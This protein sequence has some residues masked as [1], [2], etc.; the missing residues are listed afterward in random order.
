MA[1]RAGAGD[2]VVGL[3]DFP[4]A[5]GTAW[6]RRVIAVGRAKARGAGKLEADFMGVLRSPGGA[7]AV[8]GVGLR[9]CDQPVT[10][11]RV[12]PRQCPL[13]PGAGSAARDPGGGL[14]G[15]RSNESTSQ[16]FLESLLVL[17]N[18]HCQI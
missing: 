11:P 3:S 6:H 12:L 16:R 14:G 7:A 4:E 1:R 17:N 8:P 13:P 5:P 2:Q 10:P 18:S 15:P 9:A